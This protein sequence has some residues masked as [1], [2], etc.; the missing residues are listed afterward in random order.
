MILVKYLTEGVL[1]KLHHTTR[2]YT[3]K[4]KE[5]GSHLRCHS[6]GFEVYVLVYDK[7][8]D[9]WKKCSK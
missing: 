6:G 1:P 8:E 9:G 3:P 5:G 7:E 2:V 4:R